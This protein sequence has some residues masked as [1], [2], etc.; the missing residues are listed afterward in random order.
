MWVNDWASMA[1]CRGKDP[2]AL[3]VA[4]RAQHEAKRV[5]LDCP[6]RNSC[7]IEALENEIEW[8]V[9][10]GMTERERRELLRRSPGVSWRSLL[11]AAIDQNAA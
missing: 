7:L 11:E 10:G 1:A 3:F 8:G 6:V 5:C 9:W 4:G 2:D